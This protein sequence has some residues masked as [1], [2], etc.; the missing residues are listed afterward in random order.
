MRQHGETEIGEAHFD[1]ARVHRCGT[2]RL[3]SCADIARMNDAGAR[4]MRGA[5]AQ[6]QC[7]RAKVVRRRARLGR[8]IRFSFLYQGVV[9]YSKY[10]G[11]RIR[12]GWRCA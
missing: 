4:Q 6:L 11:R 12:A 8:F 2:W 9:G 7:L 3:N 1:S 10:S 5:L